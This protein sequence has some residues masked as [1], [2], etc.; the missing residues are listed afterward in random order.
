MERQQMIHSSIIRDLAEGIMVIGSDGI[1]EEVNHAALLILERKREELVGKTFARAFFTE[2]ENDAFIQ[3]VLDA[4]Y[5]RGRQQE[6][7]LPFRIGETVKQLRIVSSYL[8][9]G[10]AIIGV[11]LVIS[12][13]TELTEMRD[14]IRAMN[15]IQGLNRQLELRNRV[16][17]NTFG[18]YLSDE[19]VSEILDSPE[20]WKLGGQ[21]RRLTVMMSDLRG[22]TAMSERMQ[23]QDLI[24]MLNHYFSQM[25]EEIERYHGT[26]IEFE[27]D[28]MLVIFGAPSP[29]ESHASDAVAAALGM[30][31]RMSVVNRWNRE[32]GFETIAMGIG[33]NTDS[34][35]LGNIGSEK[36][37]KY[38]VLGAA[39][40]LTGRI[41]S[42]TTGGQIL[43]SPGTRDAI[44]E[45]LRIVH[46]MQVKPKGVD[47]DITISQ[48]TG[49]GAPYSVYLDEETVS[50]LTPITPQPVLFSVLEGKHAGGENR[51]GCLTAVSEQEAILDTAESL[52]V[53]DNLL[54]AV[55][56]GL[57]AKV[58]ETGQDGCR[59]CF[60]SRPSDFQ[61][62][63]EEIRQTSAAKAEEETYS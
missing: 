5:E 41:E 25:Y 37:T 38:G 59:I 23:P 51:E 19:I 57:Y 4:V 45:D 43:I 2:D 44:R 30:Q 32:H 1:I 53:Y 47:K 40:N 42:Y 62:W 52:A 6:S 54:L 29:T 49:I 3:T 28:G 55:G 26:L 20:G 18:R 13:I 58:T 39:V 35:I 7:Y 46:T 9:S 17:Q 10:E 11:I 16:L 60:T 63:L 24:T 48:V 12:D 50:K 15:T 8:H 34:M 33:I 36:R 22:F 31:K 21:K 56:D 27:G 61:A 14:A